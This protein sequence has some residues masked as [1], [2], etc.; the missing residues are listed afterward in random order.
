MYK[1]WAG[2]EGKG[3]EILKAK[4]TSMRRQSRGDI[5]K[6]SEDRIQTCRWWWFVV[7]PE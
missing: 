4:D 5:L 2:K 3:S 1:F 7:N 6:G